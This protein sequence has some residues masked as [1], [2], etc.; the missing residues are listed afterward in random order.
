MVMK[1]RVL[2]WTLMLICTGAQA[3]WF[4]TS[5]NNDYSI[6]LD[7]G[8]VYIS[9]PQF[10]ALCLNG[11]VEIRDAAPY[12]NDY[13]KRLTSAIFLAKASGKS[14]AFTWNDTTAPT[15]LLNSV[16]ISN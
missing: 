1:K 2:W 7:N 6:A 12:S 15:C 10:V 13:A 16:S 11:R 14:V 5:P 9:H 8:M 4:T 3:T